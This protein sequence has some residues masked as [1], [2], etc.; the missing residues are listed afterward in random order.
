[1]FLCEWKQHGSR[2]LSSSFDSFPG[3]TETDPEACALKLCP[4]GFTILICCIDK[5]AIDGFNPG[6]AVVIFTPD[7]KC[8]VHARR[9]SVR[10]A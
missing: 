9:L 2:T 3:D 4:G 8:L 6:D 1:M 7:S 10:R 5:V